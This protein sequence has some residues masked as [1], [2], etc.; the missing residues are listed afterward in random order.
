[1]GVSRQ[2]LAPRTLRI[3]PFVGESINSIHIL[4]RSIYSCDCHDMRSLRRSSAA[5][6]C[7]ALPNT[8]LCPLATP[9]RSNAVRWAPFATVTV[10]FS[11]TDVR[12]DG[13][14]VPRQERFIHNTR[15]RQTVTL[16]RPFPS[17]EGGLYADASDLDGFTDNT[18]SEHSDITPTPV[19]TTHFPR[20]YNTLRASARETLYYI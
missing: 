4:R 20:Q 16:G 2:A 15:E 17:K 10:P 8:P 11:N 12:S 6:H 9:R 5:P 19:Y 18:L 7:A 14:A 3:V 1:M 13:Q